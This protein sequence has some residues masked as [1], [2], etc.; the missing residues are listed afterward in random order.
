MIMPIA[1]SF[2]TVRPPL[3]KE[4]KCQCYVAHTTVASAGA[5][6]L[7]ILVEF[8]PNAGP[9]PLGIAGATKERTLFPV[10]SRPMLGHGGGLARLDRIPPIP[11]LRRF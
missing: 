4:R 8:G 10:G 6:L 3:V 7:S 9:E 2:L 11:P 5:D 1:G